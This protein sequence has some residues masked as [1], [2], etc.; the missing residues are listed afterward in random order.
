MRT[1]GFTNYADFK[2]VVQ[3][4]AP[5]V[6]DVYYWDSPYSGVGAGSAISDAWAFVYARGLLF[7]LALATDF[8][9]QQPAI[10]V[11]PATFAV[12]FPQAVA[13]SSHMQV[14]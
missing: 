14:S 13:L 9:S 8:Q 1:F 2:T 11:K 3:R 12:D 5:D 7:T 4:F 10:D 6:P